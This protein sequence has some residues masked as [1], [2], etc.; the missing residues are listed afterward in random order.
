MALEPWYT[1][2][3][4][5]SI[6]KHLVHWVLRICPS[7]VCTIP[8]NPYPPAHTMT[9]SSCHRMIQH[10]IG[11]SILDDWVSSQSRDSQF[12][13]NLVNM[14][15]IFTT[16]YTQN[17][18]SMLYLFPWQCVELWACWNLGDSPNWVQLLTLGQQTHWWSASKAALLPGLI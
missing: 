16:T 15:T 12:W 18:D 4:S 9:K 2:R 8:S 6:W 7:V 17:C 5:L 11:N 3:F 1:C 14:L 10:R 13:N